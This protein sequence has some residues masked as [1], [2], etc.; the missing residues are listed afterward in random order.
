MADFFYSLPIHGWRSGD[1][2]VNDDLNGRR[3]VPKKRR[4][5]FRGSRP[6][7]GV[8]EP[9]REC[10]TCGGDRGLRP[11]RALYTLSPPTAELS[12]GR[13]LRPP[14]AKGK[15][16]TRRRWCKLG[17][18]HPKKNIG[19]VWYVFTGYADFPLVSSRSDTG[20]SNTPMK[21]HAIS[22]CWIRCPLKST[23]W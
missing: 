21:F 5:A 10:R 1:A 13:A 4:R 11:A 16:K 22:I 7:R 6:S 3:G 23:A 18:T 9:Q 2:V 15:Q 19:I 20:G 17:I 8:T 14:N 12:Q